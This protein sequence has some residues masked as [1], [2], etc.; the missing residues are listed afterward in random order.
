MSCCL[1]RKKDSGCAARRE[2]PGSRPVPSTSL[3]P[4]D[5]G[6][7]CVLP[8]D[9]RAPWTCCTQILPRRPADIGPV[10]LGSQPPEPGAKLTSIGA[11][12]PV[13]DTLLHHDRDTV[14]VP[15]D[16]SRLQVP[17]HMFRGRGWDGGCGR[18]P[19]RRVSRDG[20]FSQGAPC[21]RGRVP[22]R[23]RLWLRESPVLRPGL[24]PSLPSGVS[25]TH[26]SLTLQTQ[27]VSRCYMNALGL[28]ETSK[29][30]QNNFFQESH[31]RT[32]Q[33]V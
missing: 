28:K 8:G 26:H 22:G 6:A 30:T 2:G 31:R 5:E 25:L 9:A 23:R 19:G 24:W 7:C 27:Q 18:E 14:V 1:K 16:G 15:R 32:I 11:A 29:P 10:L 17:G 4:K 20:D 21:W 12:W 33:A 13:S 3:S